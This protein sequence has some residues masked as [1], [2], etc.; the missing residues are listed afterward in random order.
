MKHRRQIENNSFIEEFYLFYLFI[1]NFINSYITLG[2]P[3][4]IPEYF[5]LSFPRPL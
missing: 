3:V 1:L 4:T 2:P 5:A